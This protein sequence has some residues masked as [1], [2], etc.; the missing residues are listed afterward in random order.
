MTEVK[1]EAGVNP[2]RSRHCIRG[3]EATKR[4]LQSLGNREGGFLRRSSSQETCRLN[5][6]GSY[7]GSRG[8][9]RTLFWRRIAASGLSCPFPLEE[10][11]FNAPIPRVP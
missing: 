10:G 7:P 2:A 8:F 5:V 3:A 1:R 4:T 6:Q 11:F 9:G